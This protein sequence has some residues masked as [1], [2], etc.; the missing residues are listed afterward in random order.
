[1]HPLLWLWSV[2]LWL[3][4]H[5]KNFRSQLNLWR[6]NC[7]FQ[8]FLL[9]YGTCGFQNMAR[10]VRTARQLNHCLLHNWEFL[11]FMLSFINCA[12]LGKNNVLPHVVITVESSV[13]HP[14]SSCCLSAPFIIG[15]GGRG[16]INRGFGEPGPPVFRQTVAP[17]FWLQIHEVRS[18]SHIIRAALIYVSCFT[19]QVANEGRLI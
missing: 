11:G 16:G 14:F 12:Q 4:H 15:L 13:I 1:M 8:G 5:T 7:C 2:K 17:V 19:W 18:Q 3:H 10:V 9:F 6:G